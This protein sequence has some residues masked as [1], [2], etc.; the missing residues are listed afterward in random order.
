MLL[1]YIRTQNLLNTFSNNFQI[2]SFASLYSRMRMKEKVL[3]KT[4]KISL[5]NINTQ[6]SKNQI[7]T[8][9]DT[10]QKLK[11]KVYGSVV[12]ALKDLKNSPQ[13]K[14]NQLIYLVVSL[15]IDPSKGD[16]V[17]RGIFKMPGGSNKIPKLMVFTSPAMQETALKAG[18]DFIADAQTYKDIQEGKIEFDKCICTLD[19]MPSLKTVGRILGPKG[20]MP[21]V[22]VG[23]ACT[24]DNLE[25]II[26][27]IKMGSREF[28]TDVWGQI[29]TPLGKYDFPEKNI[30]MNIDSF[31]NSLQEKKPESV[32]NR[33]F[34][35]AYL[36]TYKQSFKI[37]MKSLDPK[38]SHY[39][40]N[41]L[42][43]E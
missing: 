41:D 14:E 9:D 23:T 18:A 29:Q 3:S 22:K 4:D 32:K 7:N 30:L 16:Q 8:K 21:S 24:S 27:E 5:N 31:M 37:D 39:F 10:I 15:N 43:L 36:Y 26:K 17:V 11:A 25:K 13:M 6:D 40:M 19:T 38:S 33:Y 1:K 28:K 12:E 34:L 42:K 20:L 2:K 35:Y